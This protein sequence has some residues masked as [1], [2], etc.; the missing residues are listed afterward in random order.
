MKLFG[1][2]ELETVGDGFRFAIGLRNAN[3]KSMRLGLVVGV[4]IFVCDNLAVWKGC[5]LS[6]LPTQGKHTPPTSSSSF[7]RPQLCSCLP[8]VLGVN[9]GCGESK[10][11]KPVD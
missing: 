8:L 5:Y 7:S 4:R 1:V 6:I 3:D 2:M 11:P 9:T 10:L